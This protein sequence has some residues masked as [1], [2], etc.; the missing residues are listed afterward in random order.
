[1][2]SRGQRQRISILMSLTQRLNKANLNIQIVE[3]SRKGWNGTARVH[4]FIQIPPILKLWLRGGEGLISRVTLRRRL[5]KKKAWKRQ[6][7]RRPG[8]RGKTIRFC[9]CRWLFV[10]CRSVGGVC[11]R[12]AHPTKTKCECAARF[13]VT[14][15]PWAA[16]EKIEQ[17]A[18][19]D[20]TSFRCRLLRRSADRLSSV[21]SE[22][23]FLL[24]L[25][26]EIDELLQE[27]SRAKNEEIN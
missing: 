3:T 18:I 7:R 26:V 21:Q 6:H 15:C 24:L 16:S 2:A 1:M 25:G 17:V 4:C 27:A 10:C 23:E 13:H 12:S 19:S 8:T 9:L 20:E 22:N 11:S 5:D 14:T